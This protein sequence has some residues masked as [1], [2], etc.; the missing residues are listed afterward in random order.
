MAV[1]EALKPEGEWYA[2]FRV[3]ADHVVIFA[4][5][6]FRHRRADRATREEAVRYGRS[7]RVPESQLDWAE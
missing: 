1:A 3:G 6:V 2:D 7:V 5:R 4:G